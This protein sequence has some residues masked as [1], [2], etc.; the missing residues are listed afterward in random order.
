MQFEQQEPAIAAAQQNLNFR[1]YWHMILERRWLVITSFFT[2]LLLTAI[3]LVRAT[4]IY[5]ASVRLQIDREMGNPLDLRDNFTMDAREQD[6]L[7]T[8]YKNLQSRTLLQT[9]VNSL[10]LDKDPRYSKAVDPVVALQKDLTIAPIRLSRLVEVRVEHSDRKI[11]T[12]IANLLAETFIKQNLNQKVNSSFEAVTW[13]RSQVQDAETKVQRAEADLQ[14]YR[15]KNDEVSLEEGENIVRQG[16]IQAQ[17]ELG[18]IRAEAAQAQQ[19]MAE[20]QRMIDS[21]EPLDTIPA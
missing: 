11:A 9:I 18:R 8:Q 16:L 4:P 2:I 15:K 13:L 6:Y 14:G 3:Y 10:R 1:H 20:I 12:K 5:S 19:A 21:G 17:T 7:Q